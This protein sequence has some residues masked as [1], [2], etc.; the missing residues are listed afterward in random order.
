[1]NPTP[2]THLQYRCQGPAGVLASFSHLFCLLQ[3]QSLHLIAGVFY[4]DPSFSC[5]ISLYINPIQI[6]MQPIRE[7]GFD[8]MCAQRDHWFDVRMK[9]YTVVWNVAK[10]DAR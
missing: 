2:L 8:K 5:S 3:H 6:E 10:G 4:Q 7:K 1:M 9:R